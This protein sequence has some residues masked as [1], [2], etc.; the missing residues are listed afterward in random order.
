MLIV[1]TIARIRRE[2]FIKGKTI[3]EIARD[4]KVSRNTVRKVLRSGETS[5]EYERLVQPRP[6]LGR[7]ASEL[8]GLLAA[9]AGKSAREQLT[10]IRID[11]VRHV[12]DL[13]DQKLFRHNRRNSL[14]S[15]FVTRI[16]GSSARALETLA[17]FFVH[18]SRLNFVHYCFH[19]GQPAYRLALSFANTLLPQL[20]GFARRG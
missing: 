4:L 1:E 7:W 20:E 18:S 11:A 5:F 3:K 17:G 19:F 12:R 8:D 13:I 16:D 2:H 15:F 9:N 10:L 14:F 6:K